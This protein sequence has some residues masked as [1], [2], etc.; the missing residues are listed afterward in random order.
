VNKTDYFNSLTASLFLKYTCC[1][2]YNAFPC[3][4]DIK[5]T[6]DRTELLY[7]GHVIIKMLTWSGTKC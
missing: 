5:E 4:T 7:I 2:Q 3:N 1:G 6:Y